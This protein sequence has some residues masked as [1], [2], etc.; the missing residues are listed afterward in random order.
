MGGSDGA[1]NVAGDRS[2]WVNLSTYNSSGDTYLFQLFPEGTD[3]RVNTDKGNYRAGAISSDQSGMITSETNIIFNRYCLGEL[4]PDGSVAF[5]DANIKNPT[6]II[7][8][9]D[10][11]ELLF[12]ISQGNQASG[13]DILQIQALVRGI[14]GNSDFTAGNMFARIN[15]Y[16]DFQ[17]AEADSVT[18][19]V[20]E[21]NLNYISNAHFTK[22]TAREAHIRVEG[23]FIWQGGDN[24]YLGSS[25]GFIDS[26]YAD[27]IAV[28][29][30][31]STAFTFNFYVNKIDAA[32]TDFT[33]D[34]GN[35]AA[36]NFYINKLDAS[37]ALFYLGTTTKLDNSV[38]NIDF[39]YLDTDGIGA[40]EYRIL[41]VDAWSEGF[42][43][44][45]S[46]ADFNIND[47]LLD[48]MGLE[49]N[50][51]WDGQNLILN[52]TVPEPAE[53]AAVFG[54][55]ALFAAAWRKRR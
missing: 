32:T 44:S 25:S 11:V 51:E 42:A 45:G 13:L 21:I 8:N 17:F 47:D 1:A 35:C 15:S 31:K 48:A 28:W 52:V 3:D 6:P 23:H 4:Q 30:N 27:S 40:G 2:Q 53:V 20:S 54:L 29:G 50:F 46:L 49:H 7:F 16:V 24:L 38:I 41:S 33:S 10:A 12:L 34:D 39:S 19:R 26:F 37:Q 55:L 22:T 36:V 18:L 14:A 9:S 5:N 43:E